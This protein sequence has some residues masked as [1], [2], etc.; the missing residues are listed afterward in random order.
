VPPAAPK[1]DVEVVEEAVEEAIEHDGLKTVRRWMI[2]LSVWALAATA[3]AV[4]AFIEARDAKSEQNSAQTATKAD[5]ERVQ[6]G[7]RS[8]VDELRSDVDQLPTQAEFNQ[9]QSST[10]KAQKDANSAAK[11]ATAANDD[12]AELKT[13]VEAL[14]RQVNSLETTADNGAAGN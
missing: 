4:L 5:I 10:R 9:L 2:V 12:V 14:E 8:D 13:S 6:Q 7:L 1:T 3:I 11:D